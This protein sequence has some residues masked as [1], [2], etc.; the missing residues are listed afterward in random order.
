[1]LEQLLH[2]QPYGSPNALTRALMEG[3]LAY[4]L[5]QQHKG[6]QAAALFQSAVST[7]AA[8]PA[9]E[10]LGYALICLRYAKLKAQHKEWYEAAR[11]VERGVKIESDV[12]PRSSAMVEAL[13]LSAQI[14]GKLSR[15]DD[16]KDCLSRV[17][18]MRAMIESPRP[19]S[20]VDVGALAAEMR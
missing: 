12:I 7:L 20:T 16:A 11:Y 8:S 14:Y 13:E 5:M 4:A 19:S 17:K 10:S 2:R 9:S 18:A 15:R 1:L 6:E 3:N